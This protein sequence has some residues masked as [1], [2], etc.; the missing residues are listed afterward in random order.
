MSDTGGP[1]PTNRGL[2]LSQ[3]AVND[4]EILWLERR[5]DDDS[6]TLYRAPL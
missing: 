4:G 3:V 6:P 2:F 5:P 1:Y